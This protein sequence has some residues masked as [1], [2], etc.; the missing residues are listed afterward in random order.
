M[1]RRKVPI[2]LFSVYMHFYYQF[3][4]LLVKNNWNQQL[5]EFPRKEQQLQNLVDY[6]VFRAVQ[7]RFF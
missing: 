4:A 7:K 1:A 3:Y 6:A 2:I 5:P